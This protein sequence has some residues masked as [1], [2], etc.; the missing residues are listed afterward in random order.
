MLKFIQFVQKRPSDNTIRIT[1]IVFGLI[2]ILAGY[3]NLIHQGDVLNESIFGYEIS[4]EIAIFIKY[5]IIALGAF[6]LIKWI[7]NKCFLAKKY[8]KY[9]QLLLALLLFTASSIIKETSE[10]DI[11]TLLVFMWLLPLFSWITGKFIT[12]TC[13]K[14]WEKVTKIRV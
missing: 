11:D 6:P 1:W 12:S 13:L 3:Y 7:I 4:K 14:Y 9:L 5:S 10:L 2:I 8:I